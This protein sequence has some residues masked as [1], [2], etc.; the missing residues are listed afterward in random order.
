MRTG[1]GSPWI[2]PAA[3]LNSE[4]TGTFAGALVGAAA[5]IFGTR[6]ERFQAKSDERSAATLRS[7][8]VKTLV[9]AELV[10][11]AAGLIGAKRMMQAAVNAVS[12]G[13]QLPQRIELSNDLPRSMPFTA[14]LGTELL[15]LSERQIDILSTLESNLAVTRQQMQDV[16][17]GQRSFGLLAATA[18]NEGIAHDMR[19]LADAF[20]SLAPDRRLTI[21]GQAPALVSDTLRRLA[22]EPAD[23]GNQT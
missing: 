20:E 2:G 4:I 11:V 15:I 10:N 23:R 19:I 18:L 16:S 22:T 5:A 17:T 7:G 21:D 13:G 1:S 8:K 9:T 14:A 6:L 12:A 3:G